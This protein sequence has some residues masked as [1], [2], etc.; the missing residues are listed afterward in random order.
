VSKSLNIFSNMS[1]ATKPIM[2]KAKTERRTLGEYLVTDVTTRPGV[3][4]VTSVGGAGWSSSASRLNLECPLLE[5]KDQ[6][7]SYYVLQTSKDYIRPH[8]VTWWRLARPQ[9]EAEVDGSNV[10]D[11]IYKEEVDAFLLDQQQ[12]WF[13]ERK[14]TGS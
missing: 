5:C 11:G 4:I 9:S 2:R 7:G 1:G 14:I 13:D 8:I 6:R 10:D 3:C 12:K